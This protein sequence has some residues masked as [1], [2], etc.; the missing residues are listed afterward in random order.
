MNVNYYLCSSFLIYKMNGFFKSIL[1]RSVRLIGLINVGLLIIGLI[2]LI[3][4]RLIDLLC[5][6][7]Y[8]DRFLYELEL[9]PF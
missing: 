3:I 2:R 8:F 1:I 5:T 7:R 4:I 6:P 9:G